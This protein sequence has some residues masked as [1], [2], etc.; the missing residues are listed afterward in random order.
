MIG[1]DLLEFPDLQRLSGYERLSD[2][3]RWATENGIAFK[4]VRKGIATTVTAFN[5]AMGIR[6]AGNDDPYSVD[7]LFGSEQRTT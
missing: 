6:T 2:V 4:R 7:A 5:A 3:E 1:P